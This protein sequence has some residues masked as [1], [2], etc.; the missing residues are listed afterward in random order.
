LVMS[1]MRSAHYTTVKIMI[2]NQTISRFCKQR[3]Q[4]SLLKK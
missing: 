3:S 2:L 1:Q 4:M